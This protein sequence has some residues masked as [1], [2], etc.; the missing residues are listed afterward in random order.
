M[1]TDRPTIRSMTEADLP[2][3][4]ELV[5]ASAFFRDYGIGPE[6]MTAKLRI[7]LAAEGHELHVALLDGAL[8]GFTWVVERGGFDRSPY[9]RLLAVSDAVHRRGVGRALMATLEER[10]GERRDLFLLVTETNQ[11]ARRFYESLG[12]AKV[13]TMPDYVK[14]G[15]AECIY[16]KGLVR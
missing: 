1:T 11:P 6:S 5:A 16:R 9:L 12:Y 10:H 8:A 13:G 7:A 15:V 4:Q 3:C 2:A 14:P